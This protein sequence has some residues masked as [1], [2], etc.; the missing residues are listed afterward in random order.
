MFVCNG[1]G[2]IITDFVGDISR[3]LEVLFLDDDEGLRTNFV[4]DVSRSFEGLLL[5][6]GEVVKERSE[7]IARKYKIP[8]S[9]DS[10]SLPAIVRPYR[11]PESAPFLEYY[12]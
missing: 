3:S 10:K 6:D 4:G 1:F 2:R 11:P 12:A 7:A 5:E 9:R 8:P